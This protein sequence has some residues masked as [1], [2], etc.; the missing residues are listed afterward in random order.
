M[1]TSGP[2]IAREVA[3]P[4]LRLLWGPDRRRPPARRPRW[5]KLSTYVLP[6]GLL[7]LVGLGLSAGAYLQE[8]RGIGQAL[9]V[10]LAA[11]SV[12]PVALIF[13]A[14]LLAW[15]IAYVME[16]LGVL[17][18]KPSE[19]WP[20]NPVQI[21]GFLV[22][23]G[24]LALVEDTG[25]TAWATAF[26]LV[27]VFLFAEPA[28]AWGAAILLVAIALLGNTVVRRRQSRRLLAEQAE[29]NQLERAR[30]SVLEERAR[31]AREMHDVVAHHM[32][33]IAVRAETA[34]YRVAGLPDPAREELATIA[35]AARAALADMRRLLGVLRAEADETPRAPQPGLGDVHEL[36]ETARRAG[37]PVTVTLRDADGVPEAVGLAAYRIVQEALANAAR[38]AP[39][40][41]VRIVG[42]VAGD[43]LEL[44]VRNGPA[45]PGIEP[46]SLPAGG[47]GHGLVGMRERAALLGGSLSA[48]RDDSGGYT[49][50]AVLPFG[51]GEEPE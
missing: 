47:S 8:T 21:L 23:L 37:M 26:S 18:A 2:A 35:T 15:R 13:R 45:V 33:M 3:G 25:V 27:P 42:R 10:V 17:D 12:L 22:V 51:G 31:I 43:R 40:G 44:A 29:L 16:F 11:G 6:L 39:G 28:N 4:L 20:W 19:A 48:G 5:I 24:A 49:V 36:V 41:M 14:P 9:T 46:P 34:P 7:A 32:S 1:E 50:T 38:H 30:R